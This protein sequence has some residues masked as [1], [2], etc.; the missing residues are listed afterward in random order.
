MITLETLLSE[1]GLHVAQPAVIAI[2]VVVGLAALL[3]GYRL[4]KLFVFLAGFA[5]GMSVGQ[6][7]TNTP[8]AILIGLVVG[9]LCYVL[10]FIGVF[11]LG[12]AV[13]VIVAFSIGLRDSVAVAVVAVACGCLAVAI[14]K[15][16]IIIYTSYF[17][18]GL[19]IGATAPALGL[20]DMTA[21][22][23]LSLLVAVVG[24]VCQYKFTA[25]KG[26]PPAAPAASS[27]QVAGGAANGASV[28]EGASGK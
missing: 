5:I 27:P 13:G 1:N 28:R 18:A 9:A 16:M 3:Y 21:Q 22:V 17:G 10:W 19:L 7:F 24:V 20:H 4:F 15:L 26:R 6:L 11:L 8:V 23:V 2:S 25:G 14:R 12:A